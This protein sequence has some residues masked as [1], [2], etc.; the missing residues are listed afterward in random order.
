MASNDQWPPVAPAGKNSGKNRSNINTKKPTKEDQ[1]QVLSGLTEMFQNTLESEV[2]LSVASS[3]DWEL[4]SCID[5]LIA[6]SSTVESQNK[7]S[8]DRGLFVL[9]SRDPGNHTEPYVQEIDTDYLKMDKT[10][11]QKQKQELKKFEKIKKTSSKNRMGS[12]RGN[13]SKLDFNY[14]EKQALGTFD[15][16]WNPPMPQSKADEKNWNDHSDLVKNALCVLPTMTQSSNPWTEGLKQAPT[17]PLSQNTSHHTSSALCGLKVQYRTAGMESSSDDDDADVVIEKELNC[18][19]PTSVPV[20]VSQLLSSSIQT[21]PQVACSYKTQ[22]ITTPSPPMTPKRSIHQTTVDRIKTAI[23]SGDKIVILIRGL[24]GSGK[25]FLA[26]S[27]VSTTIGGNPSNYIFSTDDYFVALGRGIYMYDPRK[28]SDAHTVTQ[29]RVYKAL[30]MGKTPV[31]IDN[32]NTQA[33]EM[34]PYAAMAVKFGYIIEVLE[35]DTPWANKIGEL[36]KRNSHGVPK[37]KIERM[38]M[39]F[40]PGITGKKLLPMYSLRYEPGTDPRTAKIPERSPSEAEE[41]SVNLE[42]STGT[43]PIIT[44]HLGESGDYEDPEEQIKMMERKDLEESP[45]NE[46]YK[47]SP[48]EKHFLQVFG[49]IGSERKNS[50]VSTD[51]TVIPDPVNEEVGHN[52]ENIASHCSEMQEQDE[53]FGK[54]RKRNGDSPGEEPKEEDDGVK[55]AVQ[56]FLSELTQGYNST[57]GGFPR[58]EQRQST[59]IITEFFEEQEI[60]NV[61]DIAASLLEG[62][63]IDDI[64]LCKHDENLEGEHPEF[65]KEDVHSRRHEELHGHENET[66]IEDEKIENSSGEDK[67]M[68]FIDAENLSDVETAEESREPQAQSTLGTIFNI[69]KTSI[70]GNTHDEE[71][72]TNAEIEQGKDLK[73]FSVLED[74][75]LET[76]TEPNKKSESISIDDVNVFKS[77]IAEIRAAINSTDNDVLTERIKRSDK[78]D[79]TE[80]Y[81]LENESS[82]ANAFSTA[83]ESSEKLDEKVEKEELTSAADEPVDN[84]EFV[85]S[86]EISEE[87]EILDN[88]NRITWKESPFPVDDLLLPKVSPV[89]ETIN[90]NVQKQ[91]ASTMTTYYDFN[92]SYFGVTSEP[93]YRLIPAF[94][95]LI[96]EGV[97]NPKPERPPLKLML[98]KSSMTGDIFSREGNPE[99]KDPEERDG[100]RQ[101]ME[102]FP[103]IPRAYLMEIYEKVDE[104]LDWAVE[105]LLEGGTENIIL[106][107]AE[108][109]PGLSEESSTVENEEANFNS[110]IPEP[111]QSSPDLPSSSQCPDDFIDEEEPEDEQEEQEKEKYVEEMTRNE[112]LNTPEM[113]KEP[114]TDVSDDTASTSTASVSRM[115]SIE[116]DKSPESDDP[117][118]LYLGFDCIRGL[119]QTLGIPNFH[120]PESFSPVIQIKKSIAEELYASWIQSLYQQTNAR[121]EQLDQ[122][123]AKDAELARSLERNMELVGATASDVSSEPNL[124]QIM[125]MEL[126]LAKYKNE[127]KSII[128]RETPDDLAA[129]L[130]RQMLN[131]AIPDIDPDAFNEIL[132]AHNGNFKEAF[133]VIE[134]NTGKV[135]VPC[136]T[137][138]K[139]KILMDKVKEEDRNLREKE[140][141]IIV[142]RT[143]GKDDRLGYNTA[144]AHARDSREE[145]QRQLSLKI[146]NYNKAAE[147]YRK[148][149]PGVA[150]YY[151]QV[152]RLH[153]KNI[154]AANA[155]AASAFVEAQSWDAQEIL[156]LHNLFVWEAL[157][158]L[159]E[160]LEYHLDKL[161][162]SN[163][164][165]SKIYIITGR[166]A[167]SNN[168]TS[169]IKPAV[170][171]KLNSR[172]IKFSE[173]NP[174]CLKVTLY[175]KNGTTDLKN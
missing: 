159:D 81:S 113:M 149:C 126:A 80:F 17:T 170:L 64:N 102:L 32:T 145:A 65:I 4:Q 143:G 49:A 142:V 123:M 22:I 88:I 164:R 125:D 165:S 18:I 86:G 156:D 67:D 48:E 175:R 128:S 130:S 42:H 127:L 95:R 47:P 74:P 37:D 144:L 85:Q 121:H 153:S 41:L 55:S 136:D 174:G 11:L 96:N 155:A 158:A 140:P 6:L 35:P 7:A 148:G 104:E 172:N 46:Q 139:Q 24:P 77:P 107:T 151:S 97:P 112:A 15:S 109:N 58:T 5:A 83:L 152:A 36:A 75:K 25:S 16:I 29:K 114:T 60:D 118:E 129:R 94:N 50:V 160:F 76:R 124:E 13:I 71:E 167:R 154:D 27:L 44:S 39:G 70:L 101:L 31:I 66:L 1:Q 163:K 84:P 38:L 12:F 117:V 116:D 168:G 146:Q 110:T 72:L 20:N 62:P 79:D 23:M 115:E 173:A 135:I 57:S 131:E 87:S 53:E 90:Q 28:L 138:K 157:T 2:I 43:T 119:E 89:D 51:V 54:K 59:V 30:S 133:E 61:A 105:L 108:E 150:A 45:E 171:Q 9:V 111:V 98:D 132:K 34:R 73:E 134:M 10:E 120:I 69:I 99:V 40:E 19:I 141:P 106:K 63:T 147:A 21:P 92:V 82:E 137:L 3:C 100:F 122:M 26:R 14:R 162:K 78:N 166:G 161:M 93:M 8:Q 169:K 68:S 33:W 103:Y 56:N 91:D 52:D